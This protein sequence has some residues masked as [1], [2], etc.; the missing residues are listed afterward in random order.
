MST[1]RLDNSY[2][3]LQVTR[4]ARE[5]YWQESDYPLSMPDDDFIA[6]SR[7]RYLCD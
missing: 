6:D 1:C 7:A 2:M 3:Q 4:H 5:Y